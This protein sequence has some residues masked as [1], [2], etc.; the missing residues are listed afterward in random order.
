M[1][2]TGRFYMNSGSRTVA[3][4]ISGDSFDRGSG[5]ALLWS[6][7][8]RGRGL[9][10]QW[11]TAFLVMGAA[12][13]VALGGV[14]TT[15]LETA[16]RYRTAAHH[17]DDAISQTAQL[18]AAVNDHEIQSHKLWQGTPISTAAYAHAQNQITHLF[19]IGLR[20]LHGTGEHALVAEASQVWRHQ[21]TSRGLWGPSARARPGGVTAAMQAAYGSA[22]DRVY[23]LFGQLSETAIR[24]GAHDLS[25]ADHF[26]TIGIGLLIGVFALV[27]A[28]MLYFARRLTTDVVRPVEILQVAT[29]QLRSGSLDH[30]I[31]PSTSPRSNE[32]EELAEAF[33]E[34]ASALHA[35]HGELTRRAAFDGLT[36][37]ANRTSFNERLQRHFGATERRSETVSVLF[38]DID[39]FKFVNDSI[40][41]AA[42]DALLIAVAG[43]LSECIRPGD[44]VARLGG[45]EFAIIT[46]DPTAD[47][48][49][50]D[51][52]AQRVLDA[53]TKPILL[54]GQLMSVNVSIGV[55][56]MREDTRDSASL[57]SEAD[58][59][60]YTAKRAGKGRRE[61]FDA[62][63]DSIAAPTAP[64]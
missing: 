44:F 15:Y 38:I 31:D 6:P 29:Q 59:A 64:R 25:V 8:R 2:D 11:R 51:L 14:T 46:G 37:L 47:A 62:A 19:Q 49:A 58:F 52:V 32:L 50:A 56:V 30:R 12:L 17:L 42:G 20:D 41:H 13:L 36:G 1:F 61:V 18:D 40:G 24:D 35:S 33:N 28:I 54:G 57:L 9:R 63:A 21:L 10:R 7:A 26:Q 43:L 3:A 55:S 23:F 45:D 4:E 16:S 22:Q 48:T 60:M 53:F 34:M 5:A 39:D 27:L